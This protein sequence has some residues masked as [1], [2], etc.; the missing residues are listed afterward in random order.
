[1]WC[2]DE[3]TAIEHSEC[4]TVTFM[5]NIH[6][7]EHRICKVLCGSVHI[8]YWFS[9]PYWSIPMTQ[10]CVFKMLSSEPCMAG[11]TGFLNLL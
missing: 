2:M 7:C 10:M 1:M 6:A 11:L 5:Y 8:Q 3:R 4:I 9:K